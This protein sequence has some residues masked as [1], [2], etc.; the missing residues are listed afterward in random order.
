[1]SEGTLE[2][3]QETAEQIPRHEEEIR[4]WLDRQGLLE[5]FK[6]HDRV[7]REFT[8]NVQRMFSSRGRERL[9]YAARVSAQAGSAC[10]ALDFV[11]ELQERVAREGVGLFRVG[12]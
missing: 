2:A 12:P 8:S 3:L 11:A 10:V 7:S 9:E 6:E 4:S 1:M 5:L